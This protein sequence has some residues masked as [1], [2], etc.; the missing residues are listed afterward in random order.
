[1]IFTF[2]N[3]RE[4]EIPMIL[5]KITNKELKKKILLLIV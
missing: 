3:R 2:L 4:R 1:M 5:I